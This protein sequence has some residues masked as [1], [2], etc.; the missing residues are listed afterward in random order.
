MT[1]GDHQLTEFTRRLEAVE[2]ALV[3]LQGTQDTG[4]HKGW[5][6]KTEATRHFESS[7][8]L[9]HL[10]QVLPALAALARE[11]N[12]R[13]LF[14]A[15]ADPQTGGSGGPS[16]VRRLAAGEESV[17]SAAHLAS[18]VSNPLRARMLRDLL[19]EGE[20]TTAELAAGSGASGGSLH[21][22]LNELH[23]ANLIYQPARG[24]Y[25]LTANGQYAAEM[26]FHAAREVRRA[27]PLPDQGS[28]FE[29]EPNTPPD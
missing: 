26:F 23:G 16:S 20:R 7:E 28:W 10:Q 29:E 2:R 1:D 13:L 19:I 27:S 25:R 15:A 21:Q 18:A 14:V 4:G 9:A 5:S 17:R 12:D 3:H 11:R 6:A 8:A 24:R 22:H